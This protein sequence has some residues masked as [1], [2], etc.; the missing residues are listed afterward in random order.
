MTFWN[1]SLVLCTRAF[2]S[3]LKRLG[4][5]GD[6]VGW[7]TAPL[8]FFRA[9][10]SVVRQ[11]PGY[12]SQT[13]GTARTLS[14][15]IVLFCALFVC[16]CVLYYCHRVLTQLQLTNIS[17]YKP[18]GRGFD[19]SV[20][21]FRPHYDPGLDSASYR[22]EYREYFLGVKGGWC[23]VLISLPPS[24]ACCLKFG[25][26]NLLEPSGPTQG[27]RYILLSHVFGVASTLCVQIS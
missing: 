22:N 11:I 12:N 1:S 17:I 25:S 14:K 20:T 18:G 3:Y 10:S 16:K 19:F 13:Q 6:A 26:L 8:R 15:L 21:S 24:C 23:V 5:D 4:A 2:Q 9:F 27:L 7:D